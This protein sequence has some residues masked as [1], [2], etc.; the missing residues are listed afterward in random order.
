[1]TTRTENTAPAVAVGA[2]DIDIS[3]AGAPPSFGAPVPPDAP[4]DPLW[5]R[6][7]DRATLILSV[8]AGV[9][10]AVLG[11][12]VIVDASSRTLFNS[13][14]PGTI[15]L[16]A[17]WWMVIVVFLGLAFTQMR[18]E[19]IRVTL[20]SDAL[21]PKARRIV[22]V[23]MLLIGAATF[24][25]MAYYSV[26][27]AIY[28]TQSGE[29]A[30]G[31]LGV[32][33]WPLRWVVVVGFVTLAAQLVV[34][35]RK[36]FDP[37]EDEPQHPRRNNILFV[38]GVVVGIVLAV[39]LLTGAFDRTTVGILVLVLMLV[40]VLLGFHTAVALIIPSAIGLWVLRGSN[41]LEGSLRE[42]PFTASASWSL[43]V[44]PM[45]V[46]MGVI[47][48]RSGVTGAVFETLKLWLG[49]LPGGLAVATSLS[50]AGLASASGSAIGISYAL[51]RMAVPEML[52]AN[53]KPSLA[54]GVV[55]M[56]GTLGV[57]I[58]P[59]VL[60]VLYSGVAQTPVGPQ[61]LTAIVPGII[62]A[63]G[64]TLLIIVMA[65]INP[66]IAPK[67]TGP[68]PTWGERFAALPKVLPLVFVVGV[69]IG[70]LFSGF[71]TPTEA[72]AFGALAAVIVGF[73]FGDTP[74]KKYGKLLLES[75]RDAVA[76][77]S[78]IFLL[79]IAVNVLTRIVS[80]SGLTRA[81]TE[82][83]VGLGLG[84][85][86]LLLVLIVFFLVLGAFMDELAVMLLAVPILAPV[87]ETLGIDMLWF[88]VFVVMLTQLGLVVPPVGMLTFVVHRLVQH[89]EV[90]LG[91]KI[92]LV[93]V[94]KGGMPF[95]LFSIVFI[96]VLIFV[97][98]IATWFPTVAGP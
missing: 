80:I 5:I 43:S 96:V 72:G 23:S 11:L 47:M 76:A 25:G 64:Y 53:Y 27:E 97:P 13:P 46:F 42:I 69:M 48:W 66:S 10:V 81:L 77:V 98:E 36:S 93:D 20:L 38:V 54:T 31:A 86:G 29:L 37:V 2:P 1:M 68:K 90:G 7:I 34:S 59:S 22:T 57:L 49:R 63:L 84:S 21:S 26:L 67:P 60:L 24:L 9:V 83:I 17:N 95:I 94:F 87:L 65:I 4:S 78:S 82:W 44:I 74:K 45:F 51:S 85:V 15:D 18:N 6:I 30:A 40:M 35:T 41:V 8:V 16:V 3:V 14:L 92:S 89:P 79:L 32:P 33:V 52:K 12:H 71:F 39:A 75:L 62:V 55:T 56:S 19:H 70:G 61:L 88:G 28:A 73:F 58:P 50:G 91:R